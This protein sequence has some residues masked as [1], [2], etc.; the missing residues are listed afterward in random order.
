MGWMRIR[1][2]L[3]HPEEYREMTLPT[4]HTRLL[5]PAE[6]ATSPCQRGPTGQRAPQSLTG[7]PALLLLGAYS[8]LYIGL[9]LVSFREMISWWGGENYT[10]CYFVPFVIVYLFW[11]RRKRFAGIPSNPACL[12]LIPVIFG[13][14]LYWLGE[15]GGEYYTLY[16]SSWFILAGLCWTHFGWRKLKA[17]RFAFALMLTLFP[18]PS[19]IYRTLSV[20]LQLISSTLGTWGIRLFGIPVLR[21]GN[22]IDL[23]SRQLQVI[24]AC[25]GL[26]Y[27]MPLIV[28]G[29]ILACFFR[30]PLWKR[31]LL[32]IS[33]VPLAIAVNGFRIASTGILAMR[34][35]HYATEGFGHEFGG[36][37]IFLGSLALMAGEMRILGRDARPRG[38]EC[39][40]AQPLERGRAACD[41]FATHGLTRPVHHKAEATGQIV[42]KASSGFPP[43]TPSSRRYILPLL[44]VSLLGGTLALS[45]QVN[46][47]EKIPMRAP[48]S[49]FP[50]RIGDWRGAPQRLGAH[51]LAELHL[52]DYSAVDFRSEDGREVE[53]YAAYYASQRKGK[54]IHSPETCLPGSGWIF[55]ESGKVRLPV[56]ENGKEFISVERALIQQY[57][58]TQLVY[59]WFQMR[60]RVLTSL[61]QVKLCNFQDALTMHRTDGALVRLIT[62]VGP[63]ENVESA[64][65]RLQGFT[66]QVWPVLQK[67]LPGKPKQNS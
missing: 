8:A 52:T 64:D 12:G 15:L 3:G 60:G 63:S 24:D 11:E 39:A 35:G 4:N 23:G 43:G 17:L 32:V 61:W 49:Q 44:I 48:F 26:R 31:A 56:S 66:R 54:S 22:V 16:F 6:I 40:D 29:L 19:F 14:F 28:L 18:L 21:E 7:L 36:L 27:I 38:G 1:A 57:N 5:K 41:E 53:F 37:M 30:A 62:P 33:S 13:V 59:Y 20:K 51:V 50:L 47:R 55:R 67:L 58:E 2:N 9:F 42:E 34:W 45:R 10:Y 65:R 46:F 25:N